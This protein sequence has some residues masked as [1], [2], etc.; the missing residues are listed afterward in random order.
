MMLM[1]L[2]FLNNSNERNSKS[3]T[4]THKYTQTHTKR[5]NSNRATTQPIDNLTTRVGNENATRRESTA[6]SEK[7]RRRQRLH[8]PTLANKRG[9]LTTNKTQSGSFDLKR[10]YLQF[11]ADVWRLAR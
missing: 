11:A 8:G 9:L 1:L 2:L 4:H 7:Q 5:P 6:R 3:S 10:R